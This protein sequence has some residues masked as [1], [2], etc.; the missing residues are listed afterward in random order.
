MRNILAEI[1]AEKRLTVDSAK[2]INPLEKIQR[3]LQVGNFNMSKVITKGGKSLIAE[4]K[5]QSPAKGRLNKTHTVLEMAQIY[6]LNGAKMLS[7]HTDKHFLGCNEDFIKVRQEVKLPLLRKDFV[8]DEYQIYEA[9]QLGADAVLLIVR[10]LKPAELEKF[11]NICHELGLD[12][13]VEVHDAEDLEIAQSTPA[14]FIGI[15][16]RNLKTFTTSIDNTLEL[17][18]LV[19][20]NRIII[21][22]SGIATLDDVKKVYEIGCDG[23]L[24]GEGLVR[25]E[26][27]AAQTKLFSMTT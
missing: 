11:L 14:K 27:L 22:E 7:V 18:P 12:A 17:M 8:I 15:N 9:R 6:E 4:C 24:V 20:K 1:V 10:I 25:A 23:I 5:L 16:N 3:E 26:N 19:D 21:S 2:K 13:L